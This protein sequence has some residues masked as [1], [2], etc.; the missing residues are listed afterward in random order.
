VNEAVPYL[1]PSTTFLNVFGK[2]KAPHLAG[3]FA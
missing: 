2:Q 3:L 1:L